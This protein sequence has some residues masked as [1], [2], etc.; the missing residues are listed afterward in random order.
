LSAFTK[1]AREPDNG[2]HLILLYR[3]ALTDIRTGGKGDA[4]ELLQ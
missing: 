4:T 2:E 3:R 1:S